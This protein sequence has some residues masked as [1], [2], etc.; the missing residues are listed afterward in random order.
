VGIRAVEWDGRGSSGSH[1]PV[2]FYILRLEA[3]G[4][5]QSRPVFIVK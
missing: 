5:I 3:A 1:L 2:G 4:V